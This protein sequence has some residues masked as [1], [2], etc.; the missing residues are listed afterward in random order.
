MTTHP[1]LVIW[2]DAHSNTNGWEDITDLKDDDPYEVQSVG[3]ILQSTT[4][5]KKNHVSIVQSLATEGFVD[6]ILHI[7]KKMVLSIFPLERIVNA[8][9]RADSQDHPAIP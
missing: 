8:D 3:F 6:S 1:V 4:G 9:K 5:G 7:P 2:H